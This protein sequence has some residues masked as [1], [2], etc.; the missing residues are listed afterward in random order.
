MPPHRYLT[1]QRIER[2]KSL[3]AARIA[4]HLRQLRCLPHPSAGAL[5]VAVCAAAIGRL[6]DPVVE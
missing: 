5:I 1:N 3:L 6:V 2:A 4:V